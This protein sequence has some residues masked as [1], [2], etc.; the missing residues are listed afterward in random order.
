[1]KSLPKKDFDRS[2]SETRESKSMKTLK[3]EGMSVCEKEKF[4]RQEE[5]VFLIW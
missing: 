2:I 4:Y 1:M 5:L 3:D